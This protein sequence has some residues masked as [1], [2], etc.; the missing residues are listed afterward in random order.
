MEEFVEFVRK[1]YDTD[2]FISLHEPVFLG[3]ERKYVN[4]CI[5]STF[6]SSV[7]KFVD[8]FEDMISG[9]TGSK[10]AVAAINGTAALHIA[11]ILVDVTDED[12]V[13]T[14]PL[15][16]IATSNA[17]KYTGADPVFVDV[18]RDNLGLSPEKLEFFLQNNTYQ[19]GGYTYNRN[20]DKIIRACV[21]MHTFGHP[22]RIDHII[23]VCKKY[24]I[25]VVE[26]SAEALGSYYKG[27]HLGTFGTL[28]I[29]SFNGNKPVTTGGGGMIVT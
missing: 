22:V 2:Q 21:P 19:K 14:Q 27:K 25:P 16:F 8:Q 7:G 17:I 18:D 15:T 20:T 29:F 24:G 13:I 1:L 12:E 10:Y 5:D 3:N 9:Y 28:G 6:V 26:D 4:E 23:D 11:L